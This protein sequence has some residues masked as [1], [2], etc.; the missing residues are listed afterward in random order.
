MPG[1]LAGAVVCLDA[2]DGLF[3]EN[4]AVAPEAQ[5]RGVGRT[6]VGFAEATAIRACASRSGRA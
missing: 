3:L 4:V 6:L 1:R 5:G 2:P